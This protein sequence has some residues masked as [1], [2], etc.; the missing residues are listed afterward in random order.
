MPEKVEVIH[1]MRQIARKGGSNIYN[2]TNLKRDGSNTYNE[3]NYKK[4]WKYY[5]Q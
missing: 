4:R 5:I 1:T 3:T 2:E